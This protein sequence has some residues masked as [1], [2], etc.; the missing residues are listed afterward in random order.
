VA[1]VAVCLLLPLLKSPF[2]DIFWLVISPLKCSSNPLHV[3]R[4]NSSPHMWVYLVYLQIW[5]GHIPIFHHFPSFSIIF[6]HFPSFSTGQHMVKTW[7][8]C[9]YRGM[10]IPVIPVIPGCSVRSLR[11]RWCKSYRCDQQHP[12]QAPND[13]PIDPLGFL[14]I[15]Q[16]DDFS[17]MSSVSGTGQWGILGVFLMYWKCWEIGRFPTYRL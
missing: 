5:T 11:P 10:V 7:S 2:F 13:R 8:A 16:V 12:Q 3:C 15:D 17:M 9:S 4:L 6:H 14:G 1:V